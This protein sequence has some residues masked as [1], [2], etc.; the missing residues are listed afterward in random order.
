VG[1]PR[2]ALLW[3]TFGARECGRNGLLDDFAV[4]S[5]GW[6]SGVDVRASILQQRIF[7]QL[8][9]YDSCYHGYRLLLALVCH[10]LRGAD[11]AVDSTY[12][13]SRVMQTFHENGGGMQCEGLIGFNVVPVLSNTR[14]SFGN[15][16]AH[17]CTVVQ[18]SLT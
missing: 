17:S 12:T 10:R 1:A 5:S 6:L 4:V 7:S 15:R 8:A 2:L 14:R 13:E 16:T 18:A 9:T 11:E 3:K